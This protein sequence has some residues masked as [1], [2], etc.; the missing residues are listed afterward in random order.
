MDRWQFYANNLQKF[1]KKKSSILVIGGSQRDYELLKNLQYENFQISNLKPNPDNYNFRI[2]NIDA[3]NINLKS[4]TFDYVVTHACIHHVRKPHMALLEMYR[5]SRIG[6]LIIESNDSLLMRISCRLKISEDFEVSSVDMNNKRG[7]V[8]ESGIPNYIYRWNEREII[9]TF[10]SYEPEVKHQIFFEYGNDLDNFGVQ[11]TKEKLIITKL[12]KFLIK[13]FL[14]FFKKQ[15][16][17]LAIYIDKQN[18]NKRIF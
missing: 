12:I 9:K 1:I 3:T 15:Q 10:S 14:F 18:S 6:T 7:G 16:N 4:N 2:L 11:K 13:I 8:E 5:V 17:L